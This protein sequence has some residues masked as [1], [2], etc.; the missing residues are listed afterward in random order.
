M[1]SAS[2]F[3]PKGHY[4]TLNQAIFVDLF[5]QLPSAD[6]SVVFLSPRSGEPA[7][8]LSGSWSRCLTPLMHINEQ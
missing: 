5:A 1:H 8:G 3:R 2:E 7:A 4:A 6:V